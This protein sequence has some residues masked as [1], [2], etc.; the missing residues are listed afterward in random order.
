MLAR[1]S[2]RPGFGLISLWAACSTPLSC[3]GS[4]AAFRDVLREIEKRPA[5]GGLPLLSFLILPMQR[6]TRL[7]LLTDVSTQP[8]LGL[9][10]LDRGGPGPGVLTAASPG[11][12][13]GAMSPVGPS[14]SP[15]PPCSPHM[16]LVLVGDPRPTQALKPGAQAGRLGPSPIWCPL[17]RRSA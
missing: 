15:R 8:V 12:A 5:C 11:R 16:G 13:I 9:P 6:V 4:N 7:P 14:R 1:G 2:R 10:W 3:R 17:H